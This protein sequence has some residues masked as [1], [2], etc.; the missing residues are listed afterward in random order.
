MDFL[1]TIDQAMQVGK[2]MAKAKK[3]GELLTVANMKQAFDEFL[4]RMPNDWAPSALVAFTTS[5]TITMNSK[6]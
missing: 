4:R 3:N 1:D 5:Y 2:L 6:G